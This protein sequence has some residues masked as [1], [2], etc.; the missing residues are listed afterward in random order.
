LRRPVEPLCR[1]LRFEATDGVELTGLLFEPRRSV[2]RVA[3]FLHGTGGSSIF[4]SRRT[5]ELAKEMTARRISWFP[6]NNRGA[7]LV[8]TLRGSKSAFGGMA[9]ERIRDAVHDIDGAIRMLRARGYREF[10]L[11]GHSTGANKIAVYDFYKKRNPARRY[12]LLAGGDDVGLMYEQLGA[13]RFP[14][15]LRRARALRGSDELVPASISALPMSWRSLHDMINP[16]GDYNIFPF[17]EA[18]G[19]ID[20]SRKP[21][22]RHLKAMRKPALSIY[23]DRDEHCFGD[24]SGC[25][26]AMADA[27]AENRNHE[28]V[29]L[30]DADHGFGGHE[31]ELA[32]L[33]AGWLTESL[34]RA[35]RASLHNASRNGYFSRITRS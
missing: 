22:F 31:A 15:V 18:M 13:R 30:K 21:L 7:H 3:I 25:V 5:N 19:R 9:H 20:V 17:L 28:F 4:D 26:S 1:L 6:F 11:V 12:I 2:K 14:G 8:R 16:D 23:G 24:V 35:T 29:I 33:M 32:Q 10:Y 34:R 27:L